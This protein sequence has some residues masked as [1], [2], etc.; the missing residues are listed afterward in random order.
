MPSPAEATNY[1]GLSPS[2]LLGWVAFLAV[3]RDRP[4]VF[5]STFLFIE[6]WAEKDI[7]K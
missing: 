4:G 7:G 5:V 3:D 6:G 2:A 1:F